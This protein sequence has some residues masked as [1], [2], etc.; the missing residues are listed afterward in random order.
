MY[1][2][3]LAGAQQVPEA[4]GPILSRICTKLCEMLH[5]A[6]DSNAA[7]QIMRCISILLKHQ[8]RQSSWKGVLELSGT[9]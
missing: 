1:S 4:L 7:V 3:T 2:L 9:T 6:L 5:R 8:V